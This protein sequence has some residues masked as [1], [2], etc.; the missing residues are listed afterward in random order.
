M[1]FAQP[2]RHC[3]ADFGPG[4]KIVTDMGQ[5]DTIAGLAIDS[6]GGVITA[7]SSVVIQ[8][9]SDTDFARAI[10]GGDGIVDEIG[11]HLI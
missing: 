4:G 9:G 7:G 6:A 2:R 10:H 5:D 3:N 11:P 1:G 8:A